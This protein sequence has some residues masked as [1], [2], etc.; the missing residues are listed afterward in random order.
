MENSSQP[1]TTRTFMCAVVFLDIVEYSKKP[2]ARQLVIKSRFNTLVAKGLESV[3][4]TDRIILDTGDG[5]ALCFL[6]DPEDALFVTNSIRNDFATETE[7]PELKVRIGI[8]LGPVK[9]MRDLN[10]NPN[11]VG[12]GINVAQ[13][14]M[15]FAQT[16]QILV[17][18]SYFEV[19]S[20]LTQEYSQ[21]F[22]FVG[23][24]EDK[25]V[26]E[27]ELYEVA[28]GGNGGAQDA[29]AEVIVAAD[30]LMQ[31]AQP[32]SQPAPTPQPPSQPQ[33][34]PTAPWPLPDTAT[35]AT[36]IPAPAPPG[37][38]SMGMIVGIAVAACTTII[39]AA[40]I[41]SGKDASGPLPTPAPSPIPTPSPSPSPAPAPV[42]QQTGVFVNGR[43]LSVQELRQHEAT[44]NAP[45]QRG[46]YWYDP[47]SGLYGSWGR[48]AI[49]YIRTGHAYGRV[50]ANA[51]N[52]NTGIYLNGRH[53]NSVELTR[54]QA[55]FRQ[56]IQPGSY[57][58]D[59]NT[60]NVGVEGNPAPTGNVRAA[61]QASRGNR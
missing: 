42:V 57:W 10:G 44:Y 8:N 6:G 5:A 47:T 33:P 4:A 1:P 29:P 58:L 41:F 51:S 46:Y 43:Q 21:L 15:S 39:L 38:M 48:E 52:G 45:V 31:P 16:N 56:V 37:K 30:D 55:L 53:L 9:V 18:R 17:S 35:T 22:R 34:Q 25:H 32:A 2:V 61:I 11:I 27:H 12:D 20:R 14:V 60:G 50:P 59:G 40:A 54:W 13:R 36:N 3:A 26:R 19:V 7:V 23:A 49:G 28:V 24:R